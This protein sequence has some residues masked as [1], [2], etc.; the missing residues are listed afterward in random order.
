VRSYFVVPLPNPDTDVQASYLSADYER[1][2]FN[3]S[4]CSWEDATPSNIV[5]ISSTDAPPPASSGGLS[6]GA[7]AGIAVG[8]S[9]AGLLIIIGLVL[10]LLRKRRKWMGIG[11]AKRSNTPDASKSVLDGPVFNSETTNSPEKHSRSTP[12][13]GMS[14]HQG[15]STQYSPATANAS[16]PRPPTI[17]E[18]DAAAAAIGGATVA[19]GTVRPELDGEDTHVKPKAEL[20]AE[21]TQIGEAE[22]DPVAHNPGVY[23]LPGSRVPHDVSSST[24]TPS[25]PNVST[26]DSAW[27]REHLGERAEGI[28]PDH[29]VSP[30]STYRGRRF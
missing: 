22:G 14:W 27:A 4:A 3:V 15:S 8:C 21:A 23:E 12:S 18:E 19:G 29:L 6:K 16:P 2:V 30:T 20:D 10:L 24:T 7:I 1:K 9:I 17:N 13:S 25:S 5:A 11:F 26:M 28:D